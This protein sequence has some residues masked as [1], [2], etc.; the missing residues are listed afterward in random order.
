MWWILVWLVLTPFLCFLA[1]AK[2]LADAEEPKPFKL[3][4]Y[5]RELDKLMHHAKVDSRQLRIIKERVH[6]AMKKGKK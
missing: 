6:K 2:G 4:T 3:K 5:Y 1:Y